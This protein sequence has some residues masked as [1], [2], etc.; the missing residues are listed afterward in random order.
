MIK[1]E[2]STAIRYAKAVQAVQ[3]VQA[4]GG[5][6]ANS[7]RSSR[8]LSILASCSLRPVCSL[9]EDKPYVH[10]LSY[11]A[12]CNELISAISS[13]LA[14]SLEK[15]KAASEPD[16]LAGHGASQQTQFV[17]QMSPGCSL[18]ALIFD[19]IPAE[20]VGNILQLED[21]NLTITVSAEYDWIGGEYSHKL[22]WSHP[23]LQSEAGQ[24]FKSDHLFI[25]ETGMC[26]HRMSKTLLKHY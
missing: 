15:Q 5:R 11:C 2:N 16:D 9:L 1:A 24:A 10:D 14:I 18:C 25:V 12:R 8:Y 21:P 23:A 17:L 13:L 19:W 26:I 3:A 20:A 6:C 7:F 4:R 22:E